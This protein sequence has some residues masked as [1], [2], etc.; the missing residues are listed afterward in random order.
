LGKMRAGEREEGR[1]VGRD[2][3]GQGNSLAVQP[4]FHTGVAL[5]ALVRN[6][7]CFKSR[8]IQ[9]PREPLWPAKSGCSYRRKFEIT[10]IICTFW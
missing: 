3:E 10:K 5:D 2:G 7:R 9:K 6:C 1:E 8:Q 4:S